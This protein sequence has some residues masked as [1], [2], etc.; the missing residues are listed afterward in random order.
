MSKWAPATEADLPEQVQ[1]LTAYRQAT[2]ATEQ[3]EILQHLSVRWDLLAD[4]AQGP[5]VWKA[6][7]RHMG[8]QA[9][10]MN[11]NTLLTHYWPA[12]TWGNYDN[13]LCRRR[14]PVRRS[15]FAW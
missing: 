8:P 6:L 9:L 2:T 1:Q 10:R 3:V 5:E 15:A 14:G 7:A 13:A 11:L 12:G 4:A